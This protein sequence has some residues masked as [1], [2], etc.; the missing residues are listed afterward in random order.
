MRMLGG[1]AVFA[2]SKVAPIKIKVEATRSATD[3]NY[4]ND[5]WITIHHSSPP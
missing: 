4:L 1:V 2:S 3:S 5:V